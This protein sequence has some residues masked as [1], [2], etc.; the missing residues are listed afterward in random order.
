MQDNQR[1][2]EGLIEIEDDGVMSELYADSLSLLNSA[3][4]THTGSQG[5]MQT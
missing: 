2:G 4:T 3:R 1:G 5:V